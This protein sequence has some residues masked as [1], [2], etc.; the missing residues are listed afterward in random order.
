MWR[1]INQAVVE[2]KE[3]L[4]QL[5]GEGYVNLDS[6]ASLLVVQIFFSV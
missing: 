2:T 1:Q 5:E 3:L 6:A 4:Y